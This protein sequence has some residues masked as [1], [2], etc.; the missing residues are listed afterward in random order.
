MPLFLTEA[1]PFLKVEIMQDLYFS[2]LSD[3]YVF[4]GLSTD[5][6]R[7][8][9]A[10]LERHVYFPNDKIAEKGDVDYNI[11]F[12]HR[13]EV[14]C[15]ELDEEFPALEYVTDIYRA[16][17]YFGLLQGLFKAMPHTNTY[18]ARTVVDILALNLSKWSDIRLA[19]PEITQIIYAKA[20]ASRDAKRTY[21]NPPLMTRPSV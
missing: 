3:C 8:L 9:A 20:S 13:G 19:F 12:V 1:P 16:D 5:F 17:E 14:S 10:R 7:Q 2:H 21:I 6:L 18:R 11:Y 4:Q 15:M